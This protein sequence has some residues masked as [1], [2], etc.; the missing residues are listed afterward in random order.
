LSHFETSFGFGL[1]FTGFR[2]TRSCFL[3]SFSHVGSFYTDVISPDPRFNSLERVADPSLLEPTM[4]QLVEDITS[5]AR[6]MGIEVMVYET[7][8][9]QA[10]Q[11]ALF[12]N[13]ATKLRT[14]GVHHY[15]LACD[16]VRV[17]GGEPCW[18]GDF[19]FLGQL[20]HSSGLI[21]GGDW[22]A[23]EIK[24][25]FVDSVHVQRCT[26]ARQGELFAGTWYPDDAYTPYDDTQ[27]IFASANKPAAVKQPAKSRAR[28]VTGRSRTKTKRT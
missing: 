8:R 12:N 7:Y 20:A 28:S 17:V 24:H 2:W 22:G 5:A 15:G 13:G 18:K 25:S 9:S 6:Q 26:V 16:I 11:Q 21:W 27:R 23:P 4:R 14:V 19:S 1:A 10:R 3:I